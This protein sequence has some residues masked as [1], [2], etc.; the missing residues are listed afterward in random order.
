MVGIV[1]E[2]VSFK[3]HVMSVSFKQNCFQ[4]G[5]EMSPKKW[6]FGKEEKGMAP[7]IEKL[8]AL[9]EENRSLRDR[10][11]ELTMELEEAMS[12]LSS[13]SFSKNEGSKF[14]WLESELAD[15][16]EVP[17][18]GDAVKGGEVLIKSERL[19]V[20]MKMEDET[21]RTPLFEEMGGELDG[22][23]LSSNYS[24]SLPGESIE[25]SLKVEGDD[26]WS[27]SKENVQKHEE[28]RVPEL[29]HTLQ[30]DSKQLQADVVNRGDSVIDKG[31]KEEASNVALQS[32]QLTKALEEFQKEAVNYLTRIED[33]ENKEKEES[34]SLVDAL[35]SAAAVFSSDPSREGDRMF[36]KDDPL[37][38][39]EQLSENSCKD[40]KSKL[41][42]MKLE[43]VKI[44]SEKEACSAENSALRSRFFQHG[45]DEANSIS[46]GNA[47][48]TSGPEEK[49]S[50]KCD[51]NSMEYLEKSKALEKE[52]EELKV[53]LKDMKEQHGKEKQILSER[54]KELEKSLELLNIEYEKCEDYWQQKLEDE[55]SFYEETQRLTDERQNNLEQKIAEY[56]LMFCQKVKAESRLPMIEERVS[57]ERQVTDLEEECEELRFKMKESEALQL[58]H[59]EEKEKLFFSLQE[60]EQR[61]L[62]E[63]QSHK[64]NIV[65]ACVQADFLEHKHQNS[66]FNKADAANKHSSK[67]NR[68]KVVPNGGSTSCL[69]LSNHFSCQQCHGKNAVDNLYL[70][71]EADES[72]RS[73]IFMPN[74][75]SKKNLVNEV[76]GEELDDWQ[77][78]DVE[79]LEAILSSTKER[80]HKQTLICQNQAE[81]LMQADILVQKL[82]LENA[83]LRNYL[84][85]CQEY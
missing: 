16:G 62:K 65:D 3:G 13:A 32:K 26:L 43:I 77:S 51:S 52:L 61:M 40:L 67:S 57:L 73:R 36:V 38:T 29:E 69:N 75:N 37:L 6:S 15:D 30:L 21:A 5:G 2:D 25:A 9:Q 85:Q 84:Q 83:F 22:E 31:N 41:E 34:G 64:K 20:G 11:D 14:A 46:K 59:L 54:C 71:R 17:F 19:L 4:L 33:S 58:K 23:E 45:P 27:V 50:G 82:Y 70:E 79:T 55:R 76:G 24:M 78:S 66:V 18:A 28:A 63:Q 44:L 8:E 74:S 48:V 80:L 39:E 49:D 56:D 1:I 60:M 81:R 72:G 68:T 10:N 7:M 47:Q 53:N 35:D 42:F 12:K